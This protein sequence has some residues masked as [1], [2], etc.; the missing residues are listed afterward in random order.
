VSVAVHAAEKLKPLW[1]Y[2]TGVFNNDVAWSEDAKYVG[3][4]AATGA[5][6]LDAECGVPVQ[7]RC[8]LEFAVVSSPPQNAFANVGQRSLCEL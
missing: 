1:S 4:A 7:R 5:V 8:G 2:S 6:L 3:L